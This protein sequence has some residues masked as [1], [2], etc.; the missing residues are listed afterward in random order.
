MNPSHFRISISLTALLI[1]SPRLLFFL[2][3]LP[4]PA[5]RSASSTSVSF[6]LAI[7]PSAWAANRRTNRS[8]S[9]IALTSAG[10]ALLASVPASASSLTALRRVSVSLSLSCLTSASMS[11][12]CAVTP[13]H[14]TR[15]KNHLSVFMS[16]SAARRVRVAGTAETR[17]AAPQFRERR[18][19][20]RQEID[21]PRHD[22]EHEG[23]PAGREAEDQ[24]S[25][26]R[27]F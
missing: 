11:A 12:A 1:A 20:V 8:S 15:P 24:P 6:A 3:S 25:A 7:L 4:P 19:S 21:E 2:T 22:R 18:L 27:R 17:A 14:R 10:V 5:P 26:G 13:T 23:H 16:S 9:F